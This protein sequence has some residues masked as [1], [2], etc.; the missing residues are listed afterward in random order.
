M[1]CRHAR[2]A[3]VRCLLE[4]GA[5]Q[6][7]D[8]DGLTPAQL[9]AAAGHADVAAMIEQHAEVQAALA[10]QRA[11]QSAGEAAAADGQA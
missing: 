6:L 11:A 3:C 2:L 8:A 4:A 10:A 5:S 9:A 1:A 7:P